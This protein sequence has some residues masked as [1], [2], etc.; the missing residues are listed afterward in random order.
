M[1]TYSLFSAVV[2]PGQRL[3]VV[4]VGDIRLTIATFG[5]ELQSETGRSTLKVYQT[6]MP[7]E[8]EESSDEDSDGEDE[9]GKEPTFEKSPIVIAHLTPGR[10]ETQV[11]D[12]MFMEE[13]AVEF[14]VTG[15]NTVHLVG[16]YID[17]GQPGM[18][19]GYE[20]DSDEDDSDE[21]D[22]TDGYALEDVSSDVEMDPRAVTAIEMDDD[23]S[24]DEEAPAG[25]IV[26]VVEP[27]PTSSKKDKGKK[28]ARESDVPEADEPKESKKQKKSKKQKVEDGPAVVPTVTEKEKEKETEKKSEEKKKKGGK[29]IVTTLPS[30]VTVDVR[31]VGNGPVT[32]KGQ[33]LQMRYIGKL[34]NGTVFDK[35]TSGK[36]F[37]FTLGKGEV[38]KGWDEG[39]VGLKVG[40]E[41]IIT[42]PPAAAYGS[43]KQDGIPANS[44]LRF[45]VKVL[46]VK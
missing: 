24:D 16:N 46:S 31:T 2:K 1:P 20:G 3:R 43:K 22:D 15:K 30:G 4:P 26:E 27:V 34:T 19:D 45:E 9:E 44:T 23:D 36:P 13:E 6:A 32:K 38:I 33:S 39:L 12:L 29:G 8:D 14:E 25:K 17:Q 42:C 35:N 28:R 37:S 18:P 41:A 21:D 10:I 7:E 11:L 5:E 40:S